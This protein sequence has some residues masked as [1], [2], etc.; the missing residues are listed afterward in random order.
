MK[1]PSAYKLKD[2]AA[3]I[4]C[5][6]EGDENHLIT[7]LNEIHMVEPGDIVFV[8]H[9]KYYDKALNSKATTILINK[10]TECPKGKALLISDDPFRDYNKLVRHFYPVN[11]SLKQ[12]SDTAK[13]GAGTVIMPGVYL[14]NNVTVGTNCVLHPNVVVYNDC[15]IGNNVIIHAG[16]VIGSDA[17][18]YKRRPDKLDKMISCGRVVIEDNVEIGANCTIDKGVSGDTIIGEGTI[19]DNL[20]QIAHDTQIGKMCQF[21]AQVAIAGVVK[22]EDNVIIWGQAGVRSDV[23]LGKGA[24]LLGQS[25]LGEN[26]PAGKT[27]FGSPAGEARGKMKEVAALKMLPDIIK[28]MHEK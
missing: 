19:M 13:V 6:F 20:I 5:E 11:Y 26:I 2:I 14:G 18:Y 23:T 12:I 8:D 15:V 28:K 17:F 16:T 7:G 3:L 24:I 25:G 27:Y 4:N 1:L 21:A 10:K 22:I 9:P